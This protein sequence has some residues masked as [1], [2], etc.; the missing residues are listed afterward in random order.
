MPTQSFLNLNPANLRQ[1]FVLGLNR[2]PLALPQEIAGAI[3]GAQP[4]LIALALTGARSR[5][6]RP[7]LAQTA[8]AI[9]EAARCIHA[10]PRP[11]L[12][13]QARR[14]LQKLLFK[15]DIEAARIMTG[16]VLK[17]LAP[18]GL[19]LHPFD[20]P[21]LAV[22]L[23]S[24]GVLPGMAERAYLALAQT[25]AAAEDD[26][27]GYLFHETISAENWQGF[28]KTAR[29]RFLTEL[30]SKDAAAGLALLQSR[31]AQDPAV[32]RSELVS[33]LRTG[34][35]AA[36]Q[37]FLEELANDRADSVRAAAAR[38]LSLLPGTDA[39]GERLSRALSSFKMKPPKLL[40]RGPQVLFTPPGGPSPHAVQTETFALL[41]NIAVEELAGRLDMTVEAF[42]EALPEGEDAVFSALLCTA[43][44]NG[45]TDVIRALA[46][47]LSAKA[48]DMLLTHLP[49]SGALPW[50]Q[51]VLLDRF[52][53]RLESGTYPRAFA[54][55]ALHGRLSE[56]LPRE[57]A[58]RL[59]AS[60][61]WRD[62]LA[63]FAEQDTGQRQADPESSVHTAMLMPAIAMP[64]LL[65]AID[66]LP[67]AVSRKAREF[68]LLVLALSSPPSIPAPGER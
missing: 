23:R 67:P 30:R 59:L 49:E 65:A 63:A 42:L 45:G 3:G 11:V 50:V 51:Q 37:A 4:P 41:E 15:A 24:C 44:S 38:L 36:D 27:Q 48:L 26:P 17:R 21:R 16:A 61:S 28:G 43:I 9:P 64:A 40:R 25:G 53:A 10:D 62:Y 66:P 8:E 6:A 56:P 68:A 32:L 58:E 60:A 55:A 7:A 20:L 54:L 1:S 5:F 52:M 57:M 33:A 31:S 2:S 35:S 13:G 12:P 46:P 47:R 14:H 19:R 18:L 29:V 39:Y 34:L 22:P